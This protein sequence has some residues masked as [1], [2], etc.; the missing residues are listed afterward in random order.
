[1]RLPS[2]ACISIILAWSFWACFIMDIMFF[3]R[4]PP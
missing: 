4:F 2:S 3:T 1:V